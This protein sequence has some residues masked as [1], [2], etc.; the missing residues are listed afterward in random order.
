M[1]KNEKLAKYMAQGLT[2]E[3][4]ERLITYNQNDYL[5]LEELAIK[6]D[7][8]HLLTGEYPDWITPE[9][10]Y[11]VCQSVAKSQYDP[12]KFTYSGMD[13][14]DLEMELYIWST[15]RLFKFKNVLALRTGMINRIKNLLRQATKKEVECI[16]YNKATD[17]QKKASEK[18]DRVNGDPYTVG[19]L[20]KEI[21]LNDKSTGTFEDVIGTN[22]TNLIEAD[23]INN[24]KQIKNKQVREIVIIAGYILGDLDILEKEFKQI[25]N[26]CSEQVRNN[27]KELCLKQL[28]YMDFKFKKQTGEIPKTRS[29]KNDL[30]SITIQDIIIA[31]EY[32]EELYTLCD[33]INTVEKLQNINKKEE[34]PTRLNKK[35]NLQVKLSKSLVDDIKYYLVHNNILGTPS[36]L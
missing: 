16:P 14:E 6:Y 4:A 15:I 25:V 33:D 27:L 17:E 29:R 31:M 8:P 36:L 11:K 18:F 30:K 26:S 10:H 23:L 20:N 24:I 34:T 3:Q 13:K 5:S 1:K 35:Q 12:L 19:S 32:N 21:Q 22:D 7:N 2:M 28:N 9:E